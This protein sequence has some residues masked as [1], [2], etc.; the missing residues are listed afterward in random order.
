VD[1]AALVRR[2]RAGD[3]QA[4]DTFFDANFDRVFRFALRQTSDAQTAQDLAQSTL[5]IAVR[6]LETWRGDAPL[7]TWLCTICRREALAHWDHTRRQPTAHIVA[8]EGGRRAILERIAAGGDSPE[9]AMERD[10]LAGLVHLTL[11]RLPGQYGDVLEWKYIEGCAVSEIAARLQST[12]KAVESMLT[13]ARQA[14]RQGFTELS[15]ATGD[16]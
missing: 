5:V 12:P 10:E 13:R 7:F 9:R 2:M 1:D 8:D 15:R 11:D 4:F 16:V 3:E 6:R 14:F